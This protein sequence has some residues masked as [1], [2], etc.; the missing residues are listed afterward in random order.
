[1]T[2]M[3]SAVDALTS[4]ERALGL[5]T[6]LL[7]AVARQESSLNHW[8]ARYEPGFMVT[9]IAG[10]PTAEL[11]GH[12]PTSITQATERVLR[13]TSFGLLQLMGQ[14]AREQGFAEESLLML[15]DPDIGAAWGGRKIAHLL[16]RYGLE[17]ALSAYNHGTPTDANRTSYVAPIM[18]WLNEPKEST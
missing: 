7:V 10:R 15:C 2:T 5:Q 18:T 6:G 4:A 1:M 13:S 9:Y 14:A 8:A 11:G 12:W 16:T 3:T 17:D